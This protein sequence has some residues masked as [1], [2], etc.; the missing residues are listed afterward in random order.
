ME[1]T[2][3]EES[4]QAHKTNNPLNS[5]FGVTTTA[6]GMRS[7]E[8]PETTDHIPPKRKQSHFSKPKMNKT[9]LR[10]INVGLN[11]SQH[12]SNNQTQFIQSNDSLTIDNKDFGINCAD[13][14]YNIGQGD[15]F[16]TVMNEEKEDPEVKMILP[17]F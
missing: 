1:S 9:F 14:G 13:Y 4:K 7:S 3:Y 2:N 6:F 5:V 12:E 15:K 16:M 17:L 8:I 11:R 10:D